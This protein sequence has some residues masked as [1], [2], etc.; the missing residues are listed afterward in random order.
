MEQNFPVDFTRVENDDKRTFVRL[1]FSAEFFDDL[2][3]SIASIEANSNT[4]KSTL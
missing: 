1:E 4:D 3:V 2:E